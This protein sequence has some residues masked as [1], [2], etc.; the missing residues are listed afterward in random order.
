[1]TVWTWR[2]LVA[3]VFLVRIPDTKAILTSASFDHTHLLKFVFVSQIAGV[4]FECN[5]AP[6][7]DDYGIGGFHCFT[8]GSLTLWANVYAEMS[9]EL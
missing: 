7:A 8:V 6:L 1:M 9:L 3:V 2:F 4:V 5:I